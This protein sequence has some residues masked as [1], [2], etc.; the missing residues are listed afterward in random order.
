M[1]LKSNHHFIFWYWKFQNKTSFCSCRIHFSFFLVEA[2]KPE[3]L[4]FYWSTWVCLTNFS[5]AVFSHIITHIDTDDQ[6]IRLISTQSQLLLMK[7]WPHMNIITWPDQWSWLVLLWSHGVIDQV[8]TAY[9]WPIRGLLVVDLLKKQKLQLVN[10]YDSDLK[11]FNCRLK[12]YHIVDFFN[13]FTGK[14]NWK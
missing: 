10:R 4:W 2:E 6:M 8:S 9:W 3:F 12:F 13:N 14:S 7:Q 1:Y 11:G 5:S